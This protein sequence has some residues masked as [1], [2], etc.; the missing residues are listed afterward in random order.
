MQNSAV[1]KYYA[2]RFCKLFPRFVHRG[3]TQTQNGICKHVY[4]CF[5]HLRHL[6]E[7]TVELLSFRISNG[8]FLKLKCTSLTKIKK[9]QKRRILL[10]GF[11]KCNLCNNVSHDLLPILLRDITKPWRVLIPKLSTLCRSIFVRHI[12]QCGSTSMNNPCNVSKILRKKTVVTTQLPF[13][14]N[15]TGATL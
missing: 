2:H 15:S 9:L 12:L 7:E 13:T 4:L 11:G 5:I 6:L 10:S 1:S 8:E 3:I 14:N